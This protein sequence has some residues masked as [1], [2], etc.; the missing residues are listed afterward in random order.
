MGEATQTAWD[1][2]NVYLQEKSQMIA[3][4][5]PAIL[6]SAGIT[7][8]QDNP[9]SAQLTSLCQGLK[10]AQTKRLR[11]QEFFLQENYYRAVPLCEQAARKHLEMRSFLYGVR[12]LV[13]AFL[14]YHLLEYPDQT[15]R[16]Y[17]QIEA[18]A[19]SK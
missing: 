13:G 5:I 12:D 11:A 14:C 3:Q 9:L 17:R 7:V 1:L 4:Q 16:L 18:T 2:A 19:A 6:A 10:D 15:R 8:D